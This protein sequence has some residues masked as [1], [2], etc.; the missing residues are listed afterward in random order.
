[1]ARRRGVPYVVTAHGVYRREVLARRAP[2]KRAWAALFERRHLRRALGVHV[3]FDEEANHL[4][5]LAGEVPAIV[6]RPGFTAPVEVAWNGP[7]GEYVLWLGRFDRHVKGLDIL[8]LALHG[9]PPGDRPRVR[10]HG[11]DWRGMK[12]EVARQ[13][14]RLGLSRWVMIG[15]PVYGREKWALLQGANAFLYPSRWEGCPMAVLEAAA[16][17]LPL[18]V[19]PY[20]LGR[21]LAERGGAVVSEAEPEALA[22]GIRRVLGPEGPALGRRAAE[23]VRVEF[24]WSPLARRWVDA[25]AGLRWRGDEALRP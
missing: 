2:A 20:P 5:A 4:Q 21:F 16:V 6:C 14:E 10:L 24:A 25:V 3:F 18:L 13:V 8:L 7:R 22:Q 19:G 11:P 12:R 15:E 9:L 17:G 1:M 23:I